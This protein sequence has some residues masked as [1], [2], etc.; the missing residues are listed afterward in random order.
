MEGSE[1]DSTGDWLLPAGSAPP[2]IG[3]LEAR[4]D[5]AVETARASEAAV[6]VASA[7]AV[8]AA[9][10]ARR[11]AE[12]AERASE[13]AFAAGQAAAAP[14]VWEDERLRAFT[15]RADRVVARLRAVEQQLTP[16]QG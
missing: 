9:G 11:A 3:E 8:D 13:A 5:E 16:M 4:I 2:R 7:A 10:E 1:R 15:E 12:L 14:T 6:R